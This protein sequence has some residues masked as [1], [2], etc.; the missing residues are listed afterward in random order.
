VVKVSNPL[1]FNLADY[2]QLARLINGQEVTLKMKVRAGS[3]TLT[4]QG[5]YISILPEAIEMEEE[6][7]PSVQEILLASINDSLARQPIATP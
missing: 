3:K 4:G 6:K 7:K 1:S 5:E 2:P